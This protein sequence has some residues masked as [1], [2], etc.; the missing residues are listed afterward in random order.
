MSCTPGGLDGG[1]AD[2]GNLVIVYISAIV[3]L[4][5]LIVFPFRLYFL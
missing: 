5:Y 2:R 4:P 3:G 1:T